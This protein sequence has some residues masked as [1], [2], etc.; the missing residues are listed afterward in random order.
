MLKQASIADLKLSGLD[1]N[2]N[3]LVVVTRYY[4]RYLKKSAIHEYLGSLAPP[5]ELLH[6]FKAAEKERHDH[7]EGFTGID[8]ERKFDLS[9]EG[10]AD[11]HRLSER[12]QGQSVY[13]ICHCSRDQYCHRE[14]LL[15]MAQHYFQAIIGRL[16]HDYQIFRDRL[17]LEKLRGPEPAART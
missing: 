12:S 9:P 16:S 17:Y 1:K 7:D 3:H 11:L 4:P 5:K 15:L 8:Y 13:L 10:Y 2:N 6:E 14:L